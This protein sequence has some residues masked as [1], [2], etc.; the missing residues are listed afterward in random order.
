MLFCS[1]ALANMSVGQIKKQTNS[2]NAS[3]DFHI[4]SLVVE[5]HR[6]LKKNE[7]CADHVS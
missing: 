4:C 1:R 7:Y 5:L 2:N 6:G 3:L